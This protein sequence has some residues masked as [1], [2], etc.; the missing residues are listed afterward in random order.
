MEKKTL[1]FATGNQGKVNEFRQI[2]GDG[3]EIL[4]MKDLDLDIDIVEDGNTF[5]ENAIIKAKAVAGA[6]GKMVLAD[7]SG[8]EV[9]ALNGEP[10]IYSSRYM[11]EDTPYEIKN[12]DLLKQCEGVPDE[13][14][15]AR[16]VCVIA[17]AYPD[18]RVETV[19]GVI[20]GKLAYEPKGENGFG[21][22][23]IFYYPEKGMTTGE[24]EPEEKNAISHRGQAVRKMAELLKQ[25]G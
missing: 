1:I 16:F 14:R 23:P 9:D 24:M 20:E 17:C 19:R 4:S 22:D 13:K 18:G 11:G 10:G 7:D 8:F 6:T 3:Y 2:L 25:Q 5:E 12:A 21:Y 15:G